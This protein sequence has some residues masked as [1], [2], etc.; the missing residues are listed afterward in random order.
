MENIDF[1]SRLYKIYIHFFWNITGHLS[2]VVAVDANVL[3]SDY[4]TVLYPMG[5]VYTY[6]L[7][8]WMFIDWKLPILQAAHGKVYRRLFVCFLIW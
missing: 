6:D 1:L 7:I 2:S 5:S 3:W 8:V 4:D